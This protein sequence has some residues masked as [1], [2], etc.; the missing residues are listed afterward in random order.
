MHPPILP[1][2]SGEGLQLY[3]KSRSQF[4]TTKA[5]GN[6]VN[7]L[8][9]DFFFLLSMEFLFL[10][11]SFSISEIYTNLEMCYNGAI[12]SLAFPFLCL[13]VIDFMI[14]E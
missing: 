3:R 5:E 10:S 11:F 14:L 6:E 13:W 1:N 7:N 2:P 9:M 12:F 8:G 4:E